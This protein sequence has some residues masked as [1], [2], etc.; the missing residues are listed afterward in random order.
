MYLKEIEDKDTHS[1]LKLCSCMS[2]ELIPKFKSELGERGVITTINFND[3]PG[4]TY[5]VDVNN[6]KMEYS[7]CPICT[8]KMKLLKLKEKI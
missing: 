5:K 4:W 1:I 8:R 3:N 6:Q 7:Y 2:C